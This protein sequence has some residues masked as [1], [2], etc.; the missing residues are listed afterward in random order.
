MAW[1]RALP[2][3]RLLPLREA[4]RTADRDSLLADAR[5][6]L[7][8]ALLAFPLALI[9]ATL[10]GLPVWCGLAATGVAA[11]V[12]PVVSG[13]PLLSIGPTRATAA[14]L[15]GTFAAAGATSPDARAALLPT[16]LLMTG[17]F[18]VLVAWLRIGDVADFIPRAVVVAFLAAA[19][20]RIALLQLPMALGI[21]VDPAANAFETLWRLLTAGREL[22]NLDLLTG[23]AA[24]A[25]FTLARRT[26]GPGFA[27]L[28]AIGATAFL[29][30]IGENVA[31]SQGHAPRQGLVAYV[32]EVARSPGE[33]APT[34][35]IHGFSVLFSPAI[36]LAL[37]VVVETTAQARAASRATGRAADIHQE[38]LAAGAANLACGAVGGLAASASGGRTAAAARSGLA[39]VAAGLILIT[40]SYALVGI[41]AKVPLAALAAVVLCMER[42]QLDLD[43]IRGT[44]RADAPRR[45]AFAATLLA[46]LIA[47]LDIA[48]YLGTAVAIGFHLR[49]TLGPGPHPSLP[50]SAASRTEDGQV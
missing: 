41:L 4:I 2:R 38:I 50:E 43:E 1:L 5:A 10:A 46:G 13:T 21:T 14:L 22:L 12:A 3:P 11:L 15:V 48:L 8:I 40:A 20:I 29:A 23:L 34:F 6:G 30:M 45:A 33:L 17:G 25:V 16:L 31:L 35:S 32:G 42:G 26:Q 7:R 47:P 44:V 36:A 18:L 27:I 28:V 39:S 24:A 19:A 37:L 9:L 49:R